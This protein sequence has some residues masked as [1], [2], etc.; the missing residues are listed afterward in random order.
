MSGGRGDG[1]GDGNGMLIDMRV[2]QFLCSRLCHDLIG[3]A[4]AINSGVEFLGG[5]GADQRDEAL[6][7]LAES[8]GRLVDRLS[9]FRVALGRGGGDG[10]RAVSDARDLAAAFL[11]GGRV[12]LDWAADEASVADGAVAPNG[13]KLLL[14]LILLGADSLPRGGALGVRTARMAEGLGVAVVAA[15]SGAALREGVEAAIAGAVGDGLSAHTVVASF[16]HCLARA[17][18]TAIE[19]SAEDGEV[20]FAVLLPAAAGGPAAS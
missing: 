17:L 9:F 13:V 1:A 7:L 4:G 11:A 2:A 3:P 12:S 20:R 8:G 6:S 5:D 10:P 15:G 16:A 18:G 19:V 14:N